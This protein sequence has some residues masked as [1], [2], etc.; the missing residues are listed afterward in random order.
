MKNN[1]IGQLKVALYSRVS[2]D[3]QTTA[4]QK[5]DFEKE[6]KKEG[7]TVPKE[8]TYEDLAIS[9][10]TENRE[11]LDRLIADASKKKFDEVWIWR[12]DRLARS[13]RNGLNMLYE[14][15]KHG[16]KVK[17]LTQPLLNT[18]AM[19]SEAIRPLILW[20]AQQ[21]WEAISLRNKTGKIGG[22]QQN[23]WYEFAPYG[24]RQTEG[25]K[26]EVIPEQAKIIR[27]IYYLYC[28]DNKSTRKIADILNQDGVTPPALATRWN[29]TI[30]NPKWRHEV[31]AKYLK[32]TIYTGWV[33]RKWTDTDKDGKKGETIIVHKFT[34]DRI[35][36]DDLYQL[37]QKKKYERSTQSKRNTKRNFLFHNIIYC[38]GCESKLFPKVSIE[39]SRRCSVCNAKAVVQKSGLKIVTGKKRCEE[40]K[41]S[42]DIQTQEH[43]SYG[44][45]RN[46]K[47]DGEA[48]KRCS[49]DC[50]HVSELNLVYAITQ[51]FYQE[52]RKPNNF[53]GKVWLLYLGKKDSEKEESEEDI[54][55]EIEAEKKRV[56]DLEEQIGNAVESTI[57]KI[58]GWTQARCDALVADL[59]S[60]IQ[61]IEDRILELQQ[62]TLTGV[63]RKELQEAYGKKMKTLEGFTK[64]IRNKNPTREDAYEFMKEILNKGIVQRVYVDFKKDMLRIVSEVVNNK[65][66]GWK[67]GVW[68]QDTSPWSVDFALSQSQL[69]HQL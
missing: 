16:V 63:Q 55:A 3:Q 53:L 39:K 18:G 36:T 1:Q 23:K 12:M 17:I 33:N 66:G 67:N 35:I 22:Y 43:Y 38:L 11:H 29:R 4:L 58:R 26:L 62:K 50:G 21:E 6:L 10:R 48:K 65:S 32:D 56:K 47:W 57:R 52:L 13:V 27:R 24:Y 64:K 7:I 5:A 19:M 41:W 46:K 30:K 31:L 69:E 15:E 59:E 60:Q 42:S 68:E 51:Y 28:Y 44:Y 37:A 49:K 54:R 8:F 40:H 34:C 45:M 61:P 2:T 9:G 20:A 25:Y 14:I